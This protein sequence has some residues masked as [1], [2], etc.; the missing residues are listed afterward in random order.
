MAIADAAPAAEIPLRDIHL[1]ATPHWWP[2]APGWWVLAALAGVILVVLMIRLIRFR[3]RQKDYRRLRAELESIRHHYTIHQDQAALIQGLSRLLRRVCHYRSGQPERSS[4]HGQDWADFLADGQA[5]QS[6]LGSAA[7]VMATQAYRAMPE[8]DDPSAL[9]ELA[10]YW[11][12]KVSLSTTPSRRL[13]HAA[14]QGA[15]S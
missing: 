11:L 15:A 6:R 4:S 10:D 8:L 13:N 9:F 3:Q 7:T 14:T 5:P 12:R 1:S 2:P